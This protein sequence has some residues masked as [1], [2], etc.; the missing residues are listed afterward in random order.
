MLVTLLHSGLRAGEF[1][2]EIWIDILS[3]WLAGEVP[4]EI[5]GCANPKTVHQFSKTA[6]AACAHGKWV[7]H[8]C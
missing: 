7:V 3:S 2:A 4:S 6:E 5:S 1:E 8:F